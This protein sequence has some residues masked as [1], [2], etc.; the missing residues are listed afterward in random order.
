MR[1]TRKARRT[2][3]VEGAQLELDVEARVEAEP[4]PPPPTPPPV[5]ERTATHAASPPV[6]A[7]VPLAVLEVGRLLPVHLAK[8]PRP[9]SL[10]LQMVAAPKVPAVAFAVTTSATRYR[11]L[12]ESGRPVL[13]A[14]EFCALAVAAEH[15]RASAVWLADRLSHRSSQIE[16]GVALGGAPHRTVDD[17]RPD[18]LAP[19]GRGLWGVIEADFEHGKRMATVSVNSGGW[20]LEAWPI[21]RVLHVWG[22]RIVRVGIG[23]AVEWFE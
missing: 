19:R 4:T 14:S 10:D 22:A 7:A 12:R 23:E 20:H 3:A 18:W 16:L 8:L 5:A 15:G 1:A 9:T 6:A 13:L 17:D 21:A 2:P 11:A